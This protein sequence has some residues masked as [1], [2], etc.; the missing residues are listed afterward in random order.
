MKEAYVVCLVMYCMSAQHFARTHGI[1]RHQKLTRPLRILNSLDSG[2]F[3]RMLRM[4]P[5]LAG[6]FCNFTMPSCAVP[7]RSGAGR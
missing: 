5:V 4:A 1:P 7:A 3:H 6:E 2:Y